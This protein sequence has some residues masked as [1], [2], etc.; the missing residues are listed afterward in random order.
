M[1][2]AL[3]YLGLS[4][5]AG[6][7]EIGEDGT[8]AAI[9]TRKAKAVFLAEDAAENSRRRTSRL[10]DEHH[11]PCLVL[12]VTKEALG[13]AL[14][15]DVVAMAAVCDEGLAGAAIKAAEKTDK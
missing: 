3:G 6:R 5:R 4:R 13:K 11:I 2:K 12:P 14:G 7:L 1:S 15:R 9:R 8:L 10:A